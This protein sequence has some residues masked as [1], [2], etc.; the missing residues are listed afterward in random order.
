MFTMTF[1]QIIILILI[2]FIIGVL[3]GVSFSRPSHS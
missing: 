1:E 2:V 3:V